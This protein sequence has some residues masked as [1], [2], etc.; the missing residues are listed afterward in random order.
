MEDDG[1]GD[2]LPRPLRPHNTSSK[3][4]THLPLPPLTPPPALSY[5]YVPL[6]PQSPGGAD[7]DPLL[8]PAKVS[9]DD[10]VGDGGAGEPMGEVTGD[11]YPDDDDGDDGG[12]ASGVT[13]GVIDGVADGVIDGVTDGVVDGVVSVLACAD[14]GVDVSS[15]VAMESSS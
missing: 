15:D 9:S 7:H 11:S 8:V 1:V 13:D 2:T 10:G 6:A 5:H 3:Y 14:G 4:L 12:D